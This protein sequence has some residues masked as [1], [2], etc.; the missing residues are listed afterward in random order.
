MAF[1]IPKP[2][3]VGA[4]ATLAER[5]FELAFSKEMTTHRFMQQVLALTS[6]NLAL[7]PIP[8]LIKPAIDVYANVDSFTQ[9]PIET[10]GMER[11]KPGFR[12]NDRT[13]MFA[14]GMSAGLNA[15]TGVVDKEALSPVQIDHMLRGYFGWLGSFIVGASETVLRPATGQPGHATPDYWKTLTGGMAAELDGAPSRYVT[16]MYQQAKAVEQAYGTWKLLQKQGKAA[17]AGE[18]LQDNRELVGQYHTAERLKRLEAHLNQ[19][20]KVIESS[21]LSG[22]EKRDQVRAIQRQKDRIARHMPAI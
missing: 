13:T 18:F 19:R 17:E 14:R 16:Q 15:V 9:R 22:D 7:N 10:M 12:F 3:E 1:R 11:L 4:I 8:Q 5:G 6:D 2:F 21:E 20:M